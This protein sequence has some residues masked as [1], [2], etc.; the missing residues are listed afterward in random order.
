MTVAL[1]LE[2]AFPN[3]KTSMGK[4]FFLT[5]ISVS[6]DPPF[7]DVLLSF[8]LCLV[9]LS[10]SYWMKHKVG[11]ESQVRT[12]VHDS[13]SIRFRTREREPPQAYRSILLRVGI[14]PVA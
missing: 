3:L 14:F 5:P 9:L 12:E 13:V 4:H 11:E 10:C 6:S 8:P 2:S 1:G 7:Q